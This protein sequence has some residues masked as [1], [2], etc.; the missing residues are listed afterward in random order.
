MKQK[1]LADV[2]GQMFEAANGECAILI[3]LIVPPR[4]LRFLIG[5]SA[6]VE[7]I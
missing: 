1:C 3:L 4:F 2:G 7:L 6:H 5:H